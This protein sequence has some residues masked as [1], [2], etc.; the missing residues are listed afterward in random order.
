[1]SERVLRLAVPAGSLQEATVALFRRAGYNLSPERR[2]YYLSVDDAEMACTLIRAQEIPRYVQAG[3]MDAGL[4]GRDWILEN[5]ASVVE[6]SE[7]AYAKATRR[8]VRWVLA[9]P[10]ASPIQSVGDLEGK[11][12]ATEVVNITKRY[13]EEHGVRATVEF[14]WGATE[15]KPPDLADA[16]VDVTET[17]SSL[18]ANGLR[19]V[20]TLMES[21]PRLIASHEAWADPWKKRKIE[22]LALMLAGALAADGK[23]GLM[24]NVR[25]ADLDGV[26][27]ILP[28][29]KNPT[30]SSLADE[31]WVA[32]N[33]IV[34]ESVVRE[35]V[36][37]LK[38]A[39][40]QGIVEYPLNK[41]IE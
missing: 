21:T 33:T 4:T 3:L 10:E 29:L 22:D 14:S 23:V 8:P 38:Q 26:I 25:R 2:S 31:E 1:V 28:A 18:R 40:A 13:L 32:I 36:P 12:I 39:G 17:G 7:L 27:A 19:I 6:V 37:R 41:I 5:D 34:D 9:V 16:I 20:D 11:R 24:M 30:I 35:I 15:A